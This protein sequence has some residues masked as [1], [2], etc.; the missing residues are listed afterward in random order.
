MSKRIISLLLVLCFSVSVISI[1]DSDTVTIKR[2]YYESFA[3]VTTGSV[4]TGIS[5]NIKSNSIGVA[6]FPTATD[7]SLYFSAGTSSSTDSHADIDIGGLEGDVVIEFS[8]NIKTE[9]RF[10]FALFMFDKNGTET[11]VLR[12]DYDRNLVF[13]SG[14][15]YNVPLNTFQKISVKISCDTHLA[16]VYVGSGSNIQEI[17]SGVY[18]DNQ[19][20]TDVDRIRFHMLVPSSAYPDR[21]TNIYVDDI[22]V[23][24]SDVPAELLKNQG[25]TVKYVWDWLDANIV[26]DGALA[27]YMGNSV[28]LY[29]G[30]K[31]IYKNEAVYDTASAPYINDGEIFLPV[32]ALENSGLSIAGI[33]AV[34]KDGALYVPISE[35][36]DKN[37]KK[38]TYD[39]SGLII[40]ADR[41]N[42]F[43]LEHD[44][45]IFR[46]L[47]GKLVFQ[48]PSGEEMLRM[49]KERFPNN[50]H[51]RLYADSEKIALLR[52]SI[53]TDSKVSGWFDDVKSSAD[54]ILTQT[55]VVYDIY[56]GIRLL[57]ICRKARDRM[58]KLA[59]CYQMTLDA[60]YA[61]R[62]IEELNAVCSFKDWNPYHFL[63]TA[64]MME[65]VAF[66]YDWLYDYMSPSFRE[67]VKTA[68]VQK[69]LNQV[70]EDYRN[71]PGR[72]RSYKWSQSSVPDN[73]NMV[74]N[75]GA[76][77]AA[78]AIAEDEPEVTTE[79]MNSGME[80][81]KRAILM[82]APDGAWYEGIVYW[83]Y[84]TKYYTDLMSA[85]DSCFGDT[86]GY[87]DTPGI[88]QTGDY[89]AA[90]T[91]TDGFFNF[92]D[93][94][95]D[96]G[97]IESPE[98]MFLADKTDNPVLTS[99]REK[100]M[101][102]RGSGG[103]MRD[104]LW[105]NPE[106]S[107][108]M[109]DM[110]LDH[111]FKDAE[112]V[113][114]RNNWDSDAIYAGF[115]SGPTDVYH[116]HMDA[117][118]FVIDAYGTRFACDLGP[119]DYNIKDSVWNLYRY[120]AEGH[121]TLVINPGKDGGQ[122]I[123]GKA[124]IDRFES[125]KHSALAVTDL[126]DMYTD[127]VSVKRG[128]CFTNCRSTFVLR[129]EISLTAYKRVL[130]FMHTD[131]PITVASD[132][133]SARVSG[134]NGMDMLL[135]VS[136]DT[137]AGK[138]TVMEATP[139]S[140]SP[141]NS[142]QASNSAYKKLRFA[143][144]GSVK[145]ASITVTMQFVPTVGDYTLYVPENV[146]LADWS[147]D[148]VSDGIEIT[149]AKLSDT[150]LELEYTNTLGEQEADLIVA[151]YEGNKLAGVSL[152]G[153]VK[154]VHGFGGLTHELDIDTE[155]KNTKIMLWNNTVDIKPL[156]VSK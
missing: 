103:T 90:M 109:F 10:V 37:S 31:R 156:C 114:F 18:L 81:V 91:G 117:G 132:G 141:Q 28:A 22:S 70:L 17:L 51:P 139:L 95:E 38:L 120:R 55:P 152:L 102:D 40:I 147:L 89:L 115:H 27:Q 4:P 53:K 9:P 48:N 6:E 108:S 101:A 125:N 47:S 121:N 130:W 21:N 107:G 30:T 14:S 136:G 154:I 75:S 98:L 71:T 92:H 88:G 56:D 126:T 135:T 25:K 113:S 15:G 142:S 138:F 128:I 144:S 122:A 16:S 94:A 79:V 155:G 74:C 86:F 100:Q 36:C 112:A 151:V 39:K 76:L 63:D 46:M 59:F 80:L 111:Y 97:E 58:Q 29:E 129:D 110:K 8:L 41:E 61:D 146:S 49:I 85:L 1:A 62:C 143:F 44:L 82:Y 35:V 5:T 93:A 78:F 104:I 3:N 131:R 150:S 11:R 145:Q 134:K 33:K 83:Q 127:A 148:D 42:F 87:T 60:K 66:A 64:E 34:H 140:T 72:S 24:S 45:G 133:R 52:E 73:W 7:K 99:F 2:Y 77:Q 84:T 67:T 23:Y 105:Y 124:K 137:P 149:G 54:A 50:S 19:A 57:A 32:T 26:P 106:A 96:S 123:G 20:F 13:P 118:S 43:N 68:L 65:A 12:F 116:G 119:D 153:N 69:G